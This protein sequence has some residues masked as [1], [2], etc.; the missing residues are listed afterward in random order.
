MC[1]GRTGQC[2]QISKFRFVFGAQCAHAEPDRP[3]ERLHERASVL[4]IS[5]WRSDNDRDLCGAELARASD[6]SARSLRRSLDLIRR[7]LTDALDVL[8]QKRPVALLV[9]QIE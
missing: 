5:P 6:F 8:A 7:Q 2:A 4:C 1:D 3:F 9:N